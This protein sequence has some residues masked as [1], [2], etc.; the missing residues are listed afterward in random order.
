MTPLSGN[1]YEFPGAPLVTYTQAAITTVHHS[2]SDEEYTMTLPPHLYKQLESFKGV[3]R[4][5]TPMKLLLN[6][7]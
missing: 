6:Q 5:K 4:S 1:G 7:K 3:I 2:C